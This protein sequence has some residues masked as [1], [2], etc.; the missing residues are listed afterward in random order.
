MRGSPLIAAANLAKHY[1]TGGRLVHAL[2]SASFDIRP[3][4]MVALTGPSGSGKSTLLHILGCL[5]RPTEGT[6]MFMGQDAGTFSDVEL[7]RLR[8][9]S[10][11]FVF[12]QFF[13]APHLTVVE[14][15]G[16]SLLYRGDICASRKHALAKSAAEQVGLAE[17]LHHYPA[18]LSGGQRQRV[19]IARAIAGSP[20]LI[21]A[22]EPTGNLDTHSARQVLTLLRNLNL[23][24]ATIVVVTHSSEVAALCDRVLAIEDGLLRTEPTLA[25]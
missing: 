8:A 4:E 19:A 11:G 7:A 12:Q 2:R 25:C 15:V 18:Q 13:L 14:N 22:D 6:Y 5:D 1:D 17:R 10:I 16:R 9:T 24:G 23:A 21:L 20:A 3:G